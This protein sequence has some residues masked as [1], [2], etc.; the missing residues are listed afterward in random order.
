[1]NPLRLILQ[2]YGPFAQ[3]ELIDFRLLGDHRLFNIGGPTGSG[4]TSI[5]DGFCYGLLDEASGKERTSGNM[6]SDFA[7]PK[8]RTVVILD[9]QVGAKFYR[10]ERSPEQPRPK[11]RGDGFTKEGPQATLW[12]R[13]GLLD[14]DEEGNVLA[15]GASK[16]TAKVK[17]LIGGLTLDQLRQICILAQGEFRQVITANSDQRAV[18][19]GRLFETERYA[20]LERILKN[21]KTRLHR[22]LELSRERE[23][24]ILGAAGVETVAELETAVQDL[25]KVVQDNEKKAADLHTINEAARAALEKGT[26]DQEK[27]DEAAKARAAHEALIAQKPAI[28]ARIVELDRAREAQKLQDVDALRQQRIQEVTDAQKAKLTADAFLA[29]AEEGAEAAKKQLEEENKRDP[30]RLK[31]QQGIDRLGALKDKVA[32]LEMAQDA[33]AKANAHATKTQAELTS[34]EAGL[35]ALQD[36]LERAEKQLAEANTAAAGQ[37]NTE[38]AWEAAKQ[39]VETREELDRKRAE[40]ASTEKE[41]ADAQ[42]NFEQAVRIVETAR[43][44]L[45]SLQGERMQGHAAALAEALEDGSPCAVCGSEDHPD[46]ATAHGD[47]PSEQDIE[48]ARK[49]HREVET[50]RDKTQ[51][52]MNIVGNRLAGLQGVVETLARQLKEAAD[53]PMAELVAEAEKLGE[54]HKKAKEAASAL[55]ALLDALE[56]GKTR[57]AKAESEVLSLKRELASAMENL[58]AAQAILDERARDVPKEIRAPGALDEALKKAQAHLNALKSALEA[59]QKAQQ[60]AAENLSS[61]KATAA[62]KTKTLATTL[63]RAEDA[64]K[65]FEKRVAEA[66]FSDVEDYEDARREEA[67]IAAMETEIERFKEALAKAVDRLDRARKAAEKLKAPAMKA[68]QEAFQRASAA[69][70]EHLEELGKLRNALQ[71]QKDHLAELQRIAKEQGARHQRFKLVG[72]L[73]D[74]SWGGNGAGLTFERY[75]LAAMLDDVLLQTNTRFQKMTS[76]RYTLHRAEGVRTR[77]GRHGLDLDALDAYTGK[78]RPAF[79]LSGGEGFQASLSLALGLADTVQA[80]AGGIHLDAIFVDEGFGSLG[81]EDLDSVMGALEDLQEGGRLVGVISHVPELA[82]RIPARLEVEKGTQGSSARFILP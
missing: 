35:K 10:V 32:A 65:E 38:K 1:M 72:R 29:R 80:Q 7:A 60:S 68:L 41:H 8:L 76:G 30:E 48:A 73:S 26:Q 44:H 15:T 16:V 28:D 81:Q 64:Q 19:L 57:L 36:Q 3:R 12:D 53:Q 43:Q 58:K 13:T 4:K 25:G 2:A 18:I 69:L 24:A 50:T 22:A 23:H 17:Q 20:R 63:E 11:K 71:V 33:V 62:E 66:K 82:E 42:A 51:T 34:A 61:C 70:A 47:M 74:V 46:P 54:A 21:E 55:A 67:A 78:S 40:L 9:F 31:A 52:L 49:K 75:V 77:K 5:M 37:E 6:R 79:T 59:A 39:T 27:L 14:D 56:K 45:E